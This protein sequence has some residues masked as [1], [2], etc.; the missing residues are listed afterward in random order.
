MKKETM[1]K[2]LFSISVLLLAA[3]VVKTIIDYITYSTTL[4]SAPFSVFVLVN[5]IEFILPS[6]VLAVIGLFIR[7]NCNK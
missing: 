6:V 5:A 2:I 3:F 4:N 7:I 1:Y